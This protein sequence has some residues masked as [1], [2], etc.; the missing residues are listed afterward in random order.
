MDFMF[1]ILLVAC[2]AY[3]LYSAVR[4]KGRLFQADNLKEK[5][6]EKYVKVLRTIYFV[7]GF[8]MLLNSV[9]SLSNALLFEMRYYF[10]AAYTNALGEVYSDTDKRYTAEEMTA[11]INVP[12][13]TNAAGES[14]S[15]EEAKYDTAIQRKE[16]M[17]NT[18]PFLSYELLSGL[19]TGFMI[20]SIIPLVGVFV[21]MNVM[22]DKEKKKEAQAKAA[23]SGGAGGM[24]SA[25]FDFDEEAE[26]S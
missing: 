9:A 20:A 4:G 18:L 8:I 5:F 6:Q 23:A 19:T 15:V 3:I 13:P 12:A 14:V 24:P 25:A 7:L 26:D 1:P 11:I 16:G 10:T 22:T 17:E 2:A 21:A